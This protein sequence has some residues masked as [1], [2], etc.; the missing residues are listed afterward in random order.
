MNLSLS[1]RW[2]SVIRC[3]G[4]TA[5]EESPEGRRSI[6]YA[7]ATKSTPGMCDSVMFFK[8]ITIWNCLVRFPAMHF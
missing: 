4:K 2:G 3:G 5:S 1:L 8:C 7:S 6:S